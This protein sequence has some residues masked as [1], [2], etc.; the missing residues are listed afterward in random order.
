M[1][2]KR[3]R[4]GRLGGLRGGGNSGSRRAEAGKAES[5]CDPRA[6]SR[7][8]A[9]AATSRAPAG[10]AAL[11]PSPNRD[12]GGAAAGTDVAPPARRSTHLLRRPSDAFDVINN[13]LSLFSESRHADLHPTSLCMFLQI[14]REPGER[15]TCQGVGSR[16]GLLF[17]YDGYLQQCAPPH[18]ASQ[19]LTAS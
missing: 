14:K 11:D 12:P 5:R 19:L 1:H 10:R 13:C 15:R 17:S 9:A 7:V 3:R 16:I 4:I 6:G 8:S 18:A 2:R